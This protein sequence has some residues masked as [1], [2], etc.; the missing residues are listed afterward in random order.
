[1]RKP[2]N[3]LLN[4]LLRRLLFNSDKV[5]VLSA[6]EKESLRRLYGYADAEVLY[7]SVDTET[8]PHK[9]VEKSTGK[10]LQLLFLGRLH[11]CKGLHDMVEAF[12]RLYSEMPFRF[13][14]CGT[15][16]LEAFAVKEFT[17]IMGDDFSFKGI[18]SG[19]NKTTVI[20]SSD[21]F[22]LPS[23]YGEGLPMALLETM[24]AGLVPVTTDDAS[25]KNVVQHNENGI[26]VEK[27]NPEDI[28]RKLKDFLSHPDKLRKLSVNARKTIVENFDVKQMIEKLEKIYAGISE[29]AKVS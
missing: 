20:L 9:I 29:S 3:V 7:K 12:A 2:K 23:R 17:G 27:Y 19:E 24:G 22:I 4:Y 15:G 1:M 6:I 10:K 21:I 16:H 8:I 14:L 18:V 26:I 25:I 13:T 11:E 28:Y 5:I